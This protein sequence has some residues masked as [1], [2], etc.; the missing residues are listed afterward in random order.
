MGR[1]GVRPVDDT[2]VPVLQPVLTPGDA[3]AATAGNLPAPSA[4]AGRAT[5]AASEE[6]RQ[7]RFLQ[8]NCEGVRTSLPFLPQGEL[9]QFDIVVLTETWATVPTVVQN[10]YIA[11]CLARQAAGPGRPSGGVAVMYNHKLGSNTRV[12]AHED[13]CV[14]LAGDKLNLI[15]IYS[16]PSER[17]T[18]FIE[19]VSR[20]LDSV[21]LV[22]PTVLCGDLNSPLDKPNGTRY[23]VLLRTIQDRGFWIVTNPSQHTYVGPQGSSTIDM[24]ATNI[25]HE[26]ANYEGIQINLTAFGVKPHLPVALKISVPLNEQKQRRAGLGKAIDVNRLV[27]LSGKVLPP[28]P[29]IAVEEYSR[30]IVKILHDSVLQRPRKRGVP[31]MNS[32]L[33]A[34]K[35]YI[36]QAYIL[37]QRQPLMR[38]FYLFHNREYKKLVR[39]AK[40]NHAASEERR[41]IME[42]MQHQY[43]WLK[44]DRR[45]VAC[46]IPA[47]ELEAFFREMYNSSNTIPTEVQLLTSV[48]DEFTST[49]REEL[50]RQ[51]SMEEVADAIMRS[52]NGKAP[53]PDQVRN[54]H[55]KQAMVLVPALQTLFNAAYNSGVIPEIWRE[56]ILSVIP[57]GKGDPLLPSSWRGIA[58]KSVIYKLMSSIFSRRLETYLDAVQ[59]LPEEQHG[60]RKGKSTMTACAV[61]LNSIQRHLRHK[62][63]PL[64]AVFVDFKSAFDTASRRLIIEKLCQVG[65]PS[66]VLQLLVAILGEGKVMLDDG[67]SEHEALPQTTGVAQGD[68]LSPLLFSVL[69]SDLPRVIRDRHKHVDVLLYADD[70]VLYS[71][72]R[73]HLQ[74]SLATLQRYV[75]SNHLVINVAK[76]KA[77][78]FR[79]GGRLAANDAL[80]LS[81]NSI[82]YVGYFPY[83]GVEL[84]SSGTSFSRHIR[85]RVRKGFLAFHAIHKPE[86]LS[87][88][89][90]MALFDLKVGPTV[91]YGIEVIWPHLTK[92]NMAQLDR[93]KAAFL[94]RALGVH[95]TSRNRLVYLISEAPLF[96]EDLLRRFNLPRTA[97]YEEHILEW[98]EKMAD[99]D[100]DFFNTRA[101]LTNGW[102]EPC[103]EHRHIILRFAMHGFHHKICSTQGF[104]EANER[105]LCR[106]CGALCRTYHLQ[107]CRNPVPLC[108]LI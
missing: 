36:I 55:L 5:S 41:L 42:A 77:M 52:G 88:S 93:V 10:F 62:D 21:D 7:I 57:K 22:R 101:F 70:L 40:L 4:I 34:A 31:W 98:E 50:A 87:L 1:T 71:R 96:V 69:I 85:E 86:Q 65:V 6:R 102:K 99:V 108:N 82:D 72:S 13:N 3:A 33:R 46:P 106:L 56:L 61:L 92:A 73:F 94:K 81:T 58:K 38:P 95:R 9:Q 48:W 20:C 2:P 53:G 25:P 59:E 47:E 15:A 30:E 104:H 107:E 35:R 90:A 68:N 28:P 29:H 89:T 100:T 24:F 63:L 78:K 80:R 84:T 39:D 76:T 12:V 54:E 97:A 16:S 49:A 79:R 64:Y 91:S 32:G 105:C 60:F 11:E 26:Y 18:D 19:K 45:I 51:I 43:K 44:T 67:V 23:R 8:W 17:L 74:Q 103:H 75:D 83:L 66:T 37:S 27:E 14:V